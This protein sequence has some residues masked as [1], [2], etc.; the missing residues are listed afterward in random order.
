MKL[1]NPLFYN[2]E[3]EIFPVTSQNL[4]SQRELEE[5]Y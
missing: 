3:I 2:G 4:T 1:G 5:K